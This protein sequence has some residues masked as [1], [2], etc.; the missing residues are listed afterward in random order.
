VRA[1]KAFLRRQP[2]A[3]NRAEVEAQIEKQQQRADEEAAR[4]GAE[5]TPAPP[6]GAPPPQAAQP[7]QVA[8]PAPAPRAD[9][10]RGRPLRLAGL[11]LIGVGGAGL[12]LGGVF[13]GLA[14]RA[15]GDINPVGG[16]FSARSEDSR[17]RY[18]A[19]GAVAL[20]IGG[21]AAAT[22]LG[23]FLYGRKEARRLVAVPTISTGQVGAMLRVDL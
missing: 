13:I 7:A 19:A 20:A 10:Q 6:Q 12:I 15:N 16:T 23:L 3:R 14:A 2:R 8:I 5:P 22:G 18:E 9:P 4:K 1:Y 21:V 11:S 17:D